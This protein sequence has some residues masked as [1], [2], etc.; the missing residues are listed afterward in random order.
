MNVTRDTLFDGEL[1]IYQELD[2]YR[3]A[4]DAVLLAGLTKVFEGE[5]ILDLGCGCGIVGLILIKRNPAVS[6]AGIEIQSSLVEMVKQNIKAN[7]A[8]DSMEVFHCD[9]KD[10]SEVLEPASF[11]LVVSNPPYRKLQ[12]G[13]IN[14]NPQKAVAR[15]EIRATIFDVFNAARFVLKP[16]GR[17]ALIYTADRLDDMILEAARCSFR[18]KELRVIYSYPGGSAK[19]VHA[20]FRKDSGQELKIHPPFYVYVQENSKEYSPEMKS[21]YKL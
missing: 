10:I 3:F 20:L 18:M 2:G 4:I 7:K 14:P 6:I 13:R 8:H 1:I 5:R 16:K 15:H 17:L 19:L 11:D 9:M 21:L 12:S